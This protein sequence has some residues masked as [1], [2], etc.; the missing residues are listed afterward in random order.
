MLRSKNFHSHTLRYKVTFV[1]AKG[2]LDA[3]VSS[4]SVGLKLGVTT[5]KLPAMGFPM[6]RLY[7]L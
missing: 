1:T 6:V 4:M 7:Q 5:Q 2:S 3:H